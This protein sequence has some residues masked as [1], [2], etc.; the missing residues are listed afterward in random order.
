[1]PDRFRHEITYFMSVPGQ[2]NVPQLG[3]HEYWIDA[4]AARAWLEDG[5][6]E[7]VSPL[8][9]ATKTEIELSEEQEGWLQWIVDNGVTHV[10][11]EQNDSE[12]CRS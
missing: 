6:F 8:D 2:H 11:L 10:R 3:P 5:V 9:S 1:M 7:V 12:T 4:A